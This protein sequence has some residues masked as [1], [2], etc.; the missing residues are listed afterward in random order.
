MTSYCRFIGLDSKE[1]LASF[2]EFINVKANERPNRESGHSGYVFE[3]KDGEQQSR[4]ILLAGICGFILIGGLAVV[5][6]KPSF[7]H[8][9]SSQI[10]KL[11]AS[12]TPKPGEEGVDGASAVTPGVASASSV[13]SS[14]PSDGSTAT[15][16]PSSSS[17][18]VSSTS[19][20]SVSVTAT[21]QV[22]ATVAAF[23]AGG[24]SLGV[25]APVPTS[26]PTPTS[27]PT[28]TPTST[29]TSTPTVF[30][31]RTPVSSPT[32]SPSSS[33]SVSSVEQKAASNPDDPL[34][35]G[36]GI[37]SASIHHKVVFKALAD[38]WVRYQSDHR[39]ER[40]FIVRKD[41][42]LVLRATDR[43]T[44]Q[45]SNPNAVS[46][47]YN[48]QARKVMGQTKKKVLK[49]GVQTL[50]FPNDLTSQIEK[51]FKDDQPL[52]KTP[53]PGPDGFDP[54]L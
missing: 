24:D 34:D 32:P 27:T 40:K 47:V 33:A 48:G 44:F 7:R 53:D 5:F 52:P 15:V 6:L 12:H 14:G 25:P 20:S 46:Y 22:E 16:N 36:H 19:S 17:S 51:P 4:T 1:V 10:D 50:F 9:R 28:L 11:K 23:S 8:H 49:N 54:V 39:P 3:K 13:P 41:R 45:V 2:D 18:P 21:P 31:S 35:S 42:T 30:P 38:I 29:P 43:I 26:P 37:P